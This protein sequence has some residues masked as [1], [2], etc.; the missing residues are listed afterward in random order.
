VCVYVC[1]Y[2]CMYVSVCVYVYMF[3]CV[4][5]CMCICICVCVC[6]ILLAVIIRCNYTCRPIPMASR[7]LELWVRI[8]LE[9]RMFVVGVV[10]C[11]VEVSATGRS[12]VQ[13]T[14]T[15]CGVSVYDC[16]PSIMRRNWPLGGS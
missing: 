15:D 9:A 2:V 7:L 5:V 1:V 14:P 11:Q 16:E 6:Y 8:P 10:R 3:V 12:P 13:R 4:C